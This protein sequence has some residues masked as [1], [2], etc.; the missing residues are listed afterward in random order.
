[1]AFVVLTADVTVQDLHEAGLSTHYE[2]RR[3][4]PALPEDLVDNN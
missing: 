1:M 2:G 4:V 3:V